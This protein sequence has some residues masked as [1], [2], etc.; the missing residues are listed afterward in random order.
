MDRDA[1]IADLKV[2]S[3]AAEDAARDIYHM[4]MEIEQGRAMPEAK[5]SHAA[6]NLDRASEIVRRA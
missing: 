5:R 2:A 6:G 1:I 4:L 3:F